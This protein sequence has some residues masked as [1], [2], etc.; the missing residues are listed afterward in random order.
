LPTGSVFQSS[1]NKSEMQQL[2]ASG[3]W[4]FNESSDWISAS[5]AI[6]VN[7]RTASAVMQQN[8]WGGLGTTAHRR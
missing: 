8:S 1:Y 2:Q 5:R 4:E 3:R 6:E 7:N